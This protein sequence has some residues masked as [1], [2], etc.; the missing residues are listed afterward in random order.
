VEI[1][2]PAA[3]LFEGKTHQTLAEALKY[4]AAEMGASE[5]SVMR[6]KIIDET[7]GVCAF[8]ADRKEKEDWKVG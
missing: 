6:V 7:S 5:T 3:N 4:V 1:A 8:F 2:Y